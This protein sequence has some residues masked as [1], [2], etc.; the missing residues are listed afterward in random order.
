MA[1]EGGFLHDS[2]DITASQGMT[3]FNR[4]DGQTIRPRNGRKRG[5]SEFRGSENLHSSTFTTVEMNLNI[6]LGG[7]SFDTTEQH[8]I[9]RVTSKGV[10]VINCVSIETILRGY[11]P[12]K[13]TVSPND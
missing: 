6:F 3:G 1:G 5:F 10:R 9:Y 7:C 2:Q 8:I 11:E 13:M 4:R 12:F